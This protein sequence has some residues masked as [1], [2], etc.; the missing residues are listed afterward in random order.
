M[1]HEQVTLKCGHQVSIGIEGNSLA[2]QRMIRVTLRKYG[3]CT[4]CSELRRLEW[5]RQLKQREMRESF[6]Y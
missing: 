3:E 1:E 4:H 6:G 2:D 5:F